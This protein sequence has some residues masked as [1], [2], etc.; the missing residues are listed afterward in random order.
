MDCVNRVCP[1][2]F[3]FFYF[4]YCSLLVLGVVLVSFLLWRKRLVGFGFVRPWWCVGGLGTL[5][6]LP[7]ERTRA[8]ALDPVSKGRKRARKQCVCVLCCCVAL[9]CVLCWVWSAT[10]VVHRADTYQAIKKRLS[11]DQGGLGVYCSVCGAPSY[12]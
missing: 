6:H 5:E 8:E 12:E 4:L 2:L 3:F 7:A 1:D 10:H 11:C 9:R